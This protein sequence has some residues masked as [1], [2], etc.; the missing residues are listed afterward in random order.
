[1]ADG[2]GVAAAGGVMGAADGIL[3]I[4]GVTGVAGFTSGTETMG[5]SA[6]EP[7]LLEKTAVLVTGV[8]AG[9][10]EGAVFAELIAAGVV[11]PKSVFVNSGMIGA[12]E[13]IGAA[14]V[15]GGV[16]GAATGGW[17][18]GFIVGAAGGTTD[19]GGVGIVV[20]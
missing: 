13:L 18:L 16:M 14:A 7:G 10:A 5:D 6:M 1:M 4:T 9:V 2:A 11:K 12:V 19:A 17:M 20:F 3:G 15:A 8:C